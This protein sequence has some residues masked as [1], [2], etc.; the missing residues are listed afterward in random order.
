MI[1]NP[2]MDEEQYRKIKQMLYEY[3][4]ENKEGLLEKFMNVKYSTE[5]QKKICI[6]TIL[7][8]DDLEI[9]NE[10]KKTLDVEKVSERINIPIEVLREKGKEYGRYRTYEL[11]NDDPVLKELALEINGFSDRQ[12]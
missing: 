1:N 3:T 6:N 12:K 10:L 8:P 7:Y 9:I 4:L 2:K 5:E 11:L